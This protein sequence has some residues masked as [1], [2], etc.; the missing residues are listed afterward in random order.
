MVLI[1]DPDNLNQGT[2]VIIDTSA[3]TITLVEAGN[4]SSDGVTL[5]ALY[6]F[7]KEEWRNDATLIAYD[8]PMEAITSEQFEFK[9]DWELANDSTRKLIRTGGWAEVTSAGSIKREYAGIISLGNLGQTDQPYYDQDGTSIDF[10]YQ[11]PVNEAVQIFGDASNGNFDYRNSLTL[12]AREQAKTYASSDLAAIGTASLTYQ[13]YRFPLSNG[14][15][16]KVTENDVTVDA[17]GVDITYYGSPQ[18]RLIGGSNYNFSIIIDGNN[19]TAEQ[20]Y[21]AVQSALRKDSDIDAGA[22]VVNGKLTESLLEFVG[23]N[24]KTKST[25]SGG[26]FID[27][28]DSND[29]NRLTFTDDTGVERT[30]PFVAAGQ[31]SF[32]VNLQND[33]SAKYWMFFSDSYGTPSPVL[34]EDNTG[35]PITGNI[36]GNS[37]ISFDFDYDGNTQGGRTAGTDAN[38]TVVAIGLDDA[39]YVSTTATITRAVGQNISLVSALERNYNNS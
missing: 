32:N 29:T 5:Q 19:R 26:V 15:D 22:G 17:Y 33:T 12:Y 37:T 23:D 25:S 4:L 6:S 16:L 8:F 38:V 13:V 31:L 14:D 7:L 27:N 30:F 21:M 1:T 28:F 11:G 3:L 20:I 24:L 2:E 36:S 35:N 9:F 10:T 34:V 39:Q 18:S